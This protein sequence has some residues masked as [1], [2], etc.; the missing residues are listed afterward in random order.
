RRGDVIGAA[1]GSDQ[2]DEPVVGVGVQ[3]L[4]LDRE[5]QVGQF[6]D[7]A[8][9]GGQGPGARQVEFAASGGD[10]RDR[11][12]GPGGE[13]VLEFGGRRAGGRR[14]GDEDAGDPGVAAVLAEPGGPQV[15]VP[16]VGEGLAL[17]GVMRLEVGGGGAEV[18]VVLDLVGV[19]VVQVA[20]GAG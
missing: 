11:G 9:L 2:L 10:D 3:V 1:G 8:G 18:C 19:E 14:G 16:A 17:E 12:A 20:A 7:A 6:D 15:V 13:E 4:E 5:A